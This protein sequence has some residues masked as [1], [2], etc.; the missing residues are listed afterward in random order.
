MSSLCWPSITEPLVRASS[1]RYVG[2]TLTDLYPGV[3]PWID[4]TTPDIKSSASKF[5]QSLPTVSGFL[6]NPNATISQLMANRID[7]GIWTAGSQTLLLATNLNYNDTVLDLG[8]IPVSWKNIQ[9]IFN[10]GSSVDGT[11]ITFQSV[12]SGAF[13]L[14]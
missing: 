3:V 9:Q 1:R 5:A 6:F 12:G 11:S 13:V 8:V 4:P 10:S 2:P 7:V 14:S